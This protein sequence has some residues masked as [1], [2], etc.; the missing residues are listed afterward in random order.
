M[1]MK[2]GFKENPEIMFSN[3]K[4]FVQLN[5]NMC[6]IKVEIILS[7]NY[8]FR[9]QNLSFVDKNKYHALDFSNESWNIDSADLPENNQ[10]KIIHNSMKT[11][12]CSFLDGIG[13]YKYDERFDV[14]NLKK[15]YSLI[16]KLNNKINDQNL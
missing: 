8:T 14:T 6:N 9:Q 16:E 7:N 12:L 3:M 2:S 13:L 15:N 11:M 1:N 10:G 4:S 5:I